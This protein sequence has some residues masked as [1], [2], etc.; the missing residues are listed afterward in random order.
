MGILDLF[1]G[2]KEKREAKRIRDLAKRSQEK[3]GDASVRARALEGL[4]DIGTPEAISA[5][6]QRFTA[7]TEPGITDAE[8]KE[9]T[10]ELIRSF[11]DRAVEPVIS[12]LE[13]SESGISW[14]VRS[15]QQLVDEETLVDSICRILDRL[16]TQ[17]T[18]DPDKKV[19]LLKLLADYED[20]RI[21][22]T[23]A[24]FLDDPADDVR[25]AA[26]S[27]IVARKAVGEVEHVVECLLSAEAPRVR[28]AC[29]EALMELGASI[30]DRR[31]EVEAALPGEFT[32]DKSGSV[33]RA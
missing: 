20:P 8:E 17:Y 2:S 28:S 22:K 11:G 30:G 24:Q 14:G 31:E 26:L 6:L 18:R 21:P 15:L 13:S 10:L 29:A 1:G 23:A 7:R 25:M 27:T 5:L 3:Y 16:A 19:T 33:R 32:I 4:R 12:F 9:Y